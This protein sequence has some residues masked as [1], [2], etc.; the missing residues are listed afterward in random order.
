MAGGVRA[1]AFD[2][3]LVVRC[4]RKLYTKSGA[5][6]FAVHPSY[7]YSL[8]HAVFLVDRHGP[9]TTAV[10][11]VAL[12]LGCAFSRSVMACFLWVV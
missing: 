11:R 6:A 5:A 8:S 9:G 1:C 12:C 3:R 7:D 4:G 2:R 10:K